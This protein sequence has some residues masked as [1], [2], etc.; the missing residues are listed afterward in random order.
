MA[1]E[2][3]NI[4][5]L[6]Y[7]SF[8]DALVQAYTLPYVRLIA[9]QSGSKVFLLCLEQDHIALNET[10][11]EKAKKELAA[12][13]IVPVF[14]RYLPFGARAALKWIPYLSKLKKTVRENGIG[15]IHAWCTP[16]GAIGYYLAGMTRSRLVI[17][18][19]EPHAWSMVENGTWKAGGPAF[20]T[21][22]HLEKKQAQKADILIGLTESMKTYAQEKYGAGEKKFYV[23]PACIDFDAFPVFRALEK[24]EIRAGLGLNDKLVCVY[25]GKLGGI[26]LEK[27][28]FDFFAAA[29]ERW[30]D[31][32][33]AL[34]LSNAPAELIE[35]LCRQCGFPKENISVR[36]VPQHE[37]PRY[38]AAADFALNPVKPVPSKRHC[39]SIKDG[40]YW[41]SGLPVVIPAGISDDSD[42]IRQNQTGAVLDELSRNAY[43]EALGKI[44]QLLQ[45]D[46]GELEAKIKEQGRRYR[47]MQ[48]AANIYREIYGNR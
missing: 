33:H 43:L 7:W 38:L 2:R 44:D 10:E 3:R 45:G 9:Q 15:T 24:K 21:L 14:M 41:A 46:R 28:V 16:A 31:R 19:F 29:H 40:E 39:T 47:S 34:L 25:A 4:L 13:N 36:F 11:Q 18:S 35:K 8:A 6:T 26:Y 30:G 20:R 48:I 27:E 17:D 1:N 22:F 32:F 23:K 42:I 12:E 37:V 5:V